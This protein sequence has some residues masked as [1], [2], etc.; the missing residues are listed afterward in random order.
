[1]FTANFRKQGN[2][3]NTLGQSRAA[4]LRAAFSSAPGP[5]DLNNATPK[6]VPTTF[7]L[8]LANTEKKRR[9]SINLWNEIS[10][11]CI[12]LSFHM[13]SKSPCIIGRSNAKGVGTSSNVNHLKFHISR[14]DGSSVLLICRLPEPEFESR[15]CDDL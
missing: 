8:R 3:C 14:K 6:S 4:G 11:Y 9:K 2:R 10:E 12:I 5:N 13:L 7:T 15:H 1:M